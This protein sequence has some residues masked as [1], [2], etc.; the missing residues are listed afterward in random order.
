MLALAFLAAPAFVADRAPSEW[1]ANAE[2][3]WAQLSAVYLAEA[4]VPPRPPAPEIRLRIVALKGRHAARS[5]P[6]IVQLREGLEPQRL[7]AV[8]RHELAHQLLFGSCPE[9]SDDR[10]FHEAF[11]LTASDELTAWSE[12]Y[13]SRDRALQILETT[14]DLDR[15]DSRRAITRLVLHRLRPGARFSEPLSARIRR[16]RDGSR[17]RESMNA[18]ELAGDGFASDS[19]LVISRHTGEILSSEGPADVPIP[20]GSTLKPFVLTATSARVSILASGPEW[21]SCGRHGDPFV[22]RM[23]AE[24]ALVRSCNGWFLALGRQR[25]GLD[26]GPLEPI[27]G[28]L[29]LGGSET[30]ASARRTRRRP[31]E[32]I[33]LVPSLT[34]SPLSLA[35]AY[36]VLAE[37][38][39]EIL[40]VLR[41]V[42]SEGTL[43]GLPESAKLS[44]WAVKT[45][46]V[47]G[48]SGEPELGLIVAVDSDLVIVLVRSGRAPRSFASEVFEV[49]RKL[50]GSAHEAARVQ[51]LG[52]VPE[53]SIDVGCGGFGVKLGGPL[54][55]FDGWMSFSKISPGESVL[56]VNGPLMA[57]AKDV[58]ERPYVG[59]LTLSPPPERT[60]ASAEGPKA[61]RARRGSS[62]LLRTTRLAYVAGVVLAE[63]DELTG[64]RRE[65]FAR[66]VAHNLEYSPHAG[67]P[68]CDT[69]HCQ[70]FLGTRTGRSEERRALESTR[71]PWN[72]WLPFSKGGKEP[73]SVVRTTAQLELALGS[74]VSWIELGARPSWVR[75]VVSGSEIHDEP[76]EVSCEVLRSAL[77]LPS[78]PDSV[79]WSERGATFEG[80]GEGHGLGLDVRELSS[81]DEDVDG[82]LRRAFGQR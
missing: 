42:P 34:L 51:V 58:P 61:R 72:R 62:L 46:T 43:A 63:A 6:G 14:E 21:D 53:T 77:K 1:V 25:R 17:W 33:G 49:R 31:E 30:E 12:P 5:T 38:H 11:A 64:W 74:N 4:G 48:V 40:S 59:I 2:R 54:A 35:R 26:F 28:G 67:R 71:L 78:C 79:E 65:L 29:G 37:S 50:A 68:V 47:R 13:L 57:R 32:V 3:A 80:R 60:R 75:T 52:L 9:A 19:T 15:S 27:L 24:T 44:E 39:P 36:R 73:W 23:D 18:K 10:L 81:A 56:C 16:C 8:L 69:T 45:G 70:V 41:R 82:L 55:R 76:V 7:E 22:G 66:V 20:F